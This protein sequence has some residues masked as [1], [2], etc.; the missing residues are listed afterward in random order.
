MT[1]RIVLT[2]YEF[3]ELLDDSRDRALNSLKDININGNDWLVG[4][5]FEIC[6]SFKDIGILCS[7][8]AKYDRNN[9]CILLKGLDVEDSDLL[10]R[11][12]ITETEF[13]YPDDIR[14]FV[15]STIKSNLRFVCDSRG[16]EV[17]FSRGKKGWVEGQI[18][19]ASNILVS[20]QVLINSVIDD[21]IPL[22]NEEFDHLKSDDMIINTLREK[23]FR[24]LESGIILGTMN[25]LSNG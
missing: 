2:I 5:E 22:L 6:Q 25:I 21:F 23:E 9:S 19:W 16:N 3:D 1:E 8:I 24:F 15:D 7:G 14:D 18:Y 11:K 13:H 12:V 17:K 4:E 10:C 20:V